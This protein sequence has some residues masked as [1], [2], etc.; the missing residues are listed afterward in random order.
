VCVYVS[1][2]MHIYTH[3]YIYMYIYIYIF[4]YID[5]V[6]GYR[7]AKGVSVCVFLSLSRHV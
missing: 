2:S 5:C 3:I 6:R 7:Y 1:L 4:M